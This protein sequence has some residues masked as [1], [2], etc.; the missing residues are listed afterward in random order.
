MKSKGILTKGLDL[1][2]LQ[3]AENAID[4]LDQYFLE[5]TKWNQKMNLVAMGPDLKIIE[6]HFLDSLT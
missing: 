1:M 6:N 4:R 3:V 5:L 2:E